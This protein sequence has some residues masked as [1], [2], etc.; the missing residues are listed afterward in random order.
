VIRRLVER[1]G[2]LHCFGDVGREG[3]RSSGWGSYFERKARTGFEPVFPEKEAS[4]S[5][6]GE[7]EKP[8]SELP[9]DLQRIVERLTR[10]ARA[11]ADEPAG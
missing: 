2:D 1:A 3:S 11:G 10:A 5:E 4:E 7:A 6:G 8:D 9:A